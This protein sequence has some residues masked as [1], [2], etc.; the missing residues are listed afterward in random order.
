MFELLELAH[1]RR[2][3]TLI[4]SLKFS[5]QLAAS[6]RAH[7]PWGGGRGIREAHGAGSPLRSPCLL[8]TWTLASLGPYSTVIIDAITLGV[9]FGRMTLCWAW[10]VERACLGHGTAS[11]SSRTQPQC[12][13]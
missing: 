12:V 4:S 10:A 8:T 11:G 5:Q 13:S 1:K 2:A 9:C 6:A 3:P 7:G